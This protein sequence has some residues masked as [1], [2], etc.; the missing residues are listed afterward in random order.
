MQHLDLDTILE[1]LC[2]A[3]LV[4]AAA[5]PELVAVGTVA[6]EA[7]LCH[8]WPRAAVGAP[9]TIARVSRYT[10]LPSCSM[11]MAVMAERGGQKHAHNTVA[12]LMPRQRESMRKVALLRCSHAELTE[13][14]GSNASSS[15][16]DCKGCPD[17]RM[18]ETKHPADTIKAP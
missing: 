17:D 6:D 9:C 8:V 2:E 4:G 1:D 15:G 16:L 11:L 18:A 7:Q 13:A 5:E 3:G 14:T 12:C 10:G